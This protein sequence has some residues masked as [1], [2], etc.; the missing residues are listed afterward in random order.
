M[1]TA[2]RVLSIIA[3]AIGLLAFGL[4]YVRS[5]LLIF[6]GVFLWVQTVRTGSPKRVPLAMASTI[7]AA[8]TV[9]LVIGPFA[10]VFFDVINA[11]P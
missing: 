4:A 3:I 7:L 2:A 1:R 11:V 8:L 6:I 9:S 10:I 5:A